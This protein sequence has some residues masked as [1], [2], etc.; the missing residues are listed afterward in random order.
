[1]THSKENTYASI[2]LL[3]QPDCGWC[4]HA[5]KVLTIVSAD[6]PLTIT[7]IDLHSQDGQRLTAN[8]PVPYAPGILLDGHLI[9]FGRP[10]ERALRRALTNRK[11]H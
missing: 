10:S 5:K 4:E 11:E 9:A 8:N 7:E 6:H 2:T 1:M 3:T